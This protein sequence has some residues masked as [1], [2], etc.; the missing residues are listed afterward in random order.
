[1]HEEAI[2]EAAK[3]CEAELALYKLSELKAFSDIYSHVQEYRIIYDGI[4]KK[5]MHIISDNFKQAKI[6]IKRCL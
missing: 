1:M 5:L 4:C 6:Q 2:I 3:K